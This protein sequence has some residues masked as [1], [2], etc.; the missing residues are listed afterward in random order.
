V[1]IAARTLSGV[2][3]AAYTIRPLAVSKRGT[4]VTK[5]RVLPTLD[6]SDAPHLAFRAIHFCWLPELRPAQIERAIRLAAMMKFNYA[7]IEPWGALGRRKE[8][9]FGRI[10]YNAVKPVPFLHIISR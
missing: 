4:F 8:D 1:R 5:G 6:V 3:W 2:R 10:W 9:R 7:I